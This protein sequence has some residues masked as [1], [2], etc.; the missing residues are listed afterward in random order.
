MG[1]RFKTFPSEVLDHF[2]HNFDELTS[3]E[4]AVL[5]H[6]ITGSAT[7]APDYLSKIERGFSNSTY[8]RHYNQAEARLTSFGLLSDGEPTFAALEILPMKTAQRILEEMRRETKRQHD[9]LFE[10]EEKIIQLE[11]QRDD[12]DAEL[13]LKSREVE[14]MYKDVERFEPLSNLL[15]GLGHLHVDENWMTV[16][17]ALTSVELALKQKLEKLGVDLPRGASFKDLYSLVESTIKEKESRS[18]PVTFIKPEDLY[19]LRSK[20]DHWGHKY[21]NFSKDETNFIVGQ[22]TDLIKGLFEK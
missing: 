2:L 16:V 21:P 6:K 8:Y 11:N 22:V 19:S 1:N 15:R 17:V 4:K 14:S 3:I 12:L 10:R 18:L 7:T 13:R 9:E 20:I 5:E